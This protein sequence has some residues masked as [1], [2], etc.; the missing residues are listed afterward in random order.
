[1]TSSS[2]NKTAAT[3]QVG[4]EMDLWS[5]RVKAIE[6]PE[7]MTTFLQD[8]GEHATDDPDLYCFDDRDGIF[9]AMGFAFAGNQSGKHLR[10]VAVALLVAISWDGEPI[11][12]E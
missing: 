9:G 4:P 11:D 1:M 7:D 10:E 5:E 6:T 8:L 12:V 3:E 2:T